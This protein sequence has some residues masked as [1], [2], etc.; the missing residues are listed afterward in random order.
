MIV[1]CP[2]LALPQ[3]YDPEVGRFI[4]ADDIAYL[5]MGGLTSHNLFTYCG[6]NP[7]NDRDD[8]GRLSWLAK[9]AIGIGAVIV[10]A[11]VVAA[12]AATGGAA[13]FIGAAVA[14]VKAAAISGTIGAAVGAATSAVSHRVSTGSWDGAGKAALNGAVNGFADGF[15]TGG[16]M[17]GGSQV[18]SG[19]FKLAANAGLKTGTSGGIK[20]TGILSPNRLRSTQEIAKIAQKGQSFYDYGGQ[21]FKFGSVKLDIGSKTFLHLHIALTGSRHIP[22]GIIGS[23]IYGGFR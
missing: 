4:H 3:A 20:N 2:C 1:I 10:G 6:N 18:L 19:G 13:A 11:A 8:D 23:G 14:G 16:I 9:I 21:L 5:G 12:T 15:M 17:A 22:V 7:V